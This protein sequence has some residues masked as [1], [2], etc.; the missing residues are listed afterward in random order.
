MDITLVLGAGGAFGWV[1]HAGV[2]DALVDQLGFDPAKADMIGTSA[3][4]AVAAALRGGADPDA[5]VMSAMRGP[6]PEERAAVRAEMQAM[7]RTFRPLSPGL[8]RHAFGG[9]N[10]AA[11]A[12]GGLL[13]A[14]RFPTAFVRRFPGLGAGP[15]AWPGGLF[16]PAVRASDGAVVVFGRDRTDVPVADAVAASSAI[17]GMFRPKEIDGSS[18]IDGGLASPTHAGLAAGAHPDLVVVSS[19]M[20]RPSRR[21]MASLARRRLASEVEFLT[22]LGVPVVVVEPSAEAS[23]T[24]RGFPRRNPDAAGLISRDGYAATTRALA[25]RNPSFPFSGP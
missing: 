24:A 7:P 16:I 17:P 12:L 5:I 1:F 11:V 23:E 25:A 20:T 13:P 6:S 21:P 4:A 10:G 15:G 3:G 2:V 14:G 19:P 8:V 22:E 18:Y 9:G